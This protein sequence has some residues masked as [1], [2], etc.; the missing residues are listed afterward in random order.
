MVSRRLAVP[1]LPV[2]GLTAVTVTWVGTSPIPSTAICVVAILPFGLL[3]VRVMSC[4]ALG[5]GHEPPKEVPFQYC[6]API[7]TV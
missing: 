5:A 1:A 4:G 3:T 7:D 6:T 2:E